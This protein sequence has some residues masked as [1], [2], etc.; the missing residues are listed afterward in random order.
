M[1]E[2]KVEGDQVTVALSLGEHVEAVH[3]NVRFH[4]DRVRAVEVIDD[5]IGAVSWLKLVG[6]YVPGMSAIG[7]FRKDGMQI[8][9]VVHRH[10]PRGLRIE[11]EDGPF[12]EIVLGLED[13]EAA[14]AVLEAARGA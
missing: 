10:S 7:T 4:A 3:G 12:D 6:T 13:P 9:A 14:L 2:L 1:A 8:F 5:P 11:M